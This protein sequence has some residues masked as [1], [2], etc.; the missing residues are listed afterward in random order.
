MSANPPESTGPATPDAP[1]PANTP[2]GNA[3]VADQAKADAGAVATAALKGAAT[4]G[5][6]GAARG[7]IV[8]AAKTKTGRNIAIAAIAA[9]VLTLTMLANLIFGMGQNTTAVPAGR[10]AIAQTAALAAYENDGE[11]RS[12]QDAATMTGT[13]WE[14]LAA[15]QQTTKTWSGDKGTGPLGIDMAKANGEITE[16]DANDLDKAAVFVGRKLQAASQTTVSTLQTS[17][18]DAGYMDTRGPKDENILKPSEDEEAKALREN[19]KKQYMAAITALPVKDSDKVAEA[20]FK[21]AVSL[22]IGATAKCSPS[23]VTVGSPTGGDLN[24]KKKKY[25]QAIIDQVAAKGMPEKAAVIA[26]ATALQESGLQMYWNSSVPGS[27]DLADGGPEGG[28]DLGPGKKSYSVGLFQQQVNGSAFSWGTVEDAMNP[29][30]SA[31]MFLSRLLTI[32]GWENK[33]VT[34]AA[35]LVQSS[36]F[37]DAYAD[38]EV[39]AQAMVNEMKP[40]TGSYGTTTSSLGQGTDA[41]PG[42]STGTSTTAGCSPAAGG[43]GTGAAGKG[44]DYPFKDAQIYTPDPWGLYYRECT[45]FVA[46]RMNVQMGYKEG[47]PYPFTVATQGVGLFGDGGQWGTTLGSKYPVDMT[48]K[49]GAVI[50]WGPNFKSPTSETQ[51]YGH[52]A[53]VGAINDDGTV[54]VEE[55][56]FGYNHNYHTRTIPADEVSGYIHIA[57]IP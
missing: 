51:G 10:G 22:S 43:V 53:V 29:A 24:E 28:F 15:I 16:A 42:G 23:T 41:V 12:I 35:Q 26:L 50:W 11:L 36:A 55:Y 17:A 31:D 32:I 39:A 14:I 9:P 40:T 8:G 33:P 46:W 3:T 4:G 37:P 38:D 48:P 47:E 44:D 19:V 18:L 21:S 54:V 13:P 52:V 57:D 5:L 45:S 49:V 6:A 56:N 25:A 7:A 27:Q 30:K 1:G 34:V 2:N 20:V